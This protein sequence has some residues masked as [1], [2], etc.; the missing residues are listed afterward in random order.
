CIALHHRTQPGGGRRHQRRLGDWTCP[1][2]P[3]IVFQHISGE[4]AS[5]PRLVRRFTSSVA[6]LTGATGTRHR[7]FGTRYLA[8]AYR[9]EALGLRRD[10]RPGRWWRAHTI[11]RDRHRDTDACLHRPVSCPNRLTAPPMRP[12]SITKKP[13]AS[14]VRISTAK[15]VARYRMGLC[16]P[17]EL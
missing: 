12:A 5:P 11:R 6:Y 2:G 1:P 8:G 13:S 14:N 9:A 15:N 16:V 7:I 4:P 17:L 3:R 10:A